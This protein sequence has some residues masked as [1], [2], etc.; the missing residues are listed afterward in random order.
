MGPI[1][2]LKQAKK[3]VVIADGWMFIC[4]MYEIYWLGHLSCLRFFGGM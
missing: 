1:L 4:I 2:E 3:G